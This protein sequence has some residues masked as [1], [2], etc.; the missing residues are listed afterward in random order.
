MVELLLSICLSYQMINA[1]EDFS[2]RSVLSY[3]SEVKFVVFI[4]SM[5]Y[6]VNV[7]NTH[8]YGLRPYIFRVLGS[9]FFQ[10]WPFFKPL[11]IIDYR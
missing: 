2:H 5:K 6:R 11:S 4:Y 1:L 9:F 10:M 3:D 7:L 8:L